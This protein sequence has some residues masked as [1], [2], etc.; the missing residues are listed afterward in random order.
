MH[1]PA[2]VVS[3]E[4]DESQHRHHDAHTTPESPADG[5]Q[6]GCGCT[7]DGV[8]ALIAQTGDVISV[9]TS[10]PPVTG[11]ADVVV[12]RTD[13]LEPSLDSTSPPPRIDLS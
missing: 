8:V 12:N 10:E 9:F 7:A 4:S 6:L 11:A 3:A 1:Q 13:L 2:P 5:T